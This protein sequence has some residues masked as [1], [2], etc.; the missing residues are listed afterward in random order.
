M[1]RPPLPWRLAAMR[2]HSHA[3][4]RLPVATRERHLIAV[5]G[6][7]PFAGL[8]D[9]DQVWMIVG[10]KRECTTV[11]AARALTVTRGATC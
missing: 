4:Q 7:D 6:G 5:M 2:L 8:A 3:A 1:L 11:A 9:N 10:G